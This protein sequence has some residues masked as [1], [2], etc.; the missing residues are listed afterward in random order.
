MFQT[1]DFLCIGFFCHDVHEEGYI[2]GGTASYASLVASKLGKKTAVLTSVGEDFLFLDTFKQAGIQISNKAAPKTTVFDNRYDKGIR[3]QYIYNRALSL[4]ANDI[5]ALW[6]KVPIIKLCSIATEI[7]PSLFTAFPNALVGAT[8]QGLLRQWDEN[9]EITPKA[10]DWNLLSSV[11]VVLF[12]DA[13]IEGY[14]EQLATI[15]DLVEVVVMTKG[16]E[17]ATVFYQ[18]Q[19]YDFPAFPVTEVDP[20]G[21]GDVF[22]A[23]FLI[24]YAESKDIALAASFA[25]SA[26]SFVVE[27]IGVQ[28]PSLEAIQIR[29]AAYKER[30]PA[31]FV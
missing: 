8:I 25:H 22:A 27:G 7:D 1:P 10:M 23:S 15:V 4:Q 12:S 11:D 17:G 16:K 9:G 6:N 30:F 31:L 21:A 18:N 26:S 19:V 20:T 13:D 28:L 24:Q 3:T 2:L 5:P 14:E 29:W